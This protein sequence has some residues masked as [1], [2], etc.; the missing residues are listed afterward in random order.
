VD[1]VRTDISADRIASIIREERISELVLLCSVL[2]LLVTTNVGPTS[3]TLY[4][5]MMEATLSSES[6]V[7]TRAAQLYIPEDILHSHRREHHTSCN[8]VKPR[9]IIRG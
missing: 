1:L 2:Q 3:L 8:R 4:N 7:V 9:S 6:L 5:L